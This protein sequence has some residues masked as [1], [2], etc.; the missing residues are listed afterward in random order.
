MTIIVILGT[1]IVTNAPR[2]VVTIVFPL[3]FHPPW[4]ALAQGASLSPLLDSHL[5]INFGRW[6][7]FWIPGVPFVAPPFQYHLGF[8][9]GLFE[10]HSL[11][12]M[13]KG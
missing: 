7:P 4:L 3:A 1:T 6:D 8:P 9:I 11:G 12:T 2:M 5:S 10:I 13:L